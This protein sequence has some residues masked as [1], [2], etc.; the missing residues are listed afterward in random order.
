M[1]SSRKIQGCEPTFQ[2]N[3]LKAKTAVA[4]GSRCGSRAAGPVGSQTTIP[5]EVVEPRPQRRRGSALC[6]AAQ[7]CSVPGLD[8]KLRAAQ[9]LGQALR[10]DRSLSPGQALA[11]TWSPGTGH[12]LLPSLL[13]H[14]WCSLKGLRLISRNKDQILKQHGS[15]K[16]CWTQHPFPP[17]QRFPGEVPSDSV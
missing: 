13:L 14:L 12:R 15:E 4:P 8:L 9:D 7:P 10:G 11:P 5:V 2:A 6:P 3:W 1:D 17:S 16:S